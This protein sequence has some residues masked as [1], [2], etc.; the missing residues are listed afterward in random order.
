[1]FDC[2]YVYMVYIAGLAPSK[3]FHFCLITLQNA[4]P[5]VLGIVK[6]ICFVFFWQKLD[7]PFWIEQP[8]VAKTL[9]KKKNL[10]DMIYKS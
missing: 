10:T 9:L 5:K 2:Q 6:M 3:K 8:T 4:S 1:M 7:V